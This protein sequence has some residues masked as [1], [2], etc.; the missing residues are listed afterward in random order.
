[1]ITTRFVQN[2]T[3]SL[4]GEVLGDNSGDRRLADIV[5]TRH[6]RTRFAAGYDTF[7]DFSPLACIKFLPSPANAPLGP[8]G[9]E[10]LHRSLII[11]IIEPTRP[12]QH[13]AAKVS[14]AINR[15]AYLLF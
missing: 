11:Q 6:F 1:M 14:T 8:S 5:E 2:C 7:S 12:A 13:A 9:S 15:S 3:L 4:V 10:T